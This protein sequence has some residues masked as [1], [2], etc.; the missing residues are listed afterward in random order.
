MK[1][2]FLLSAFAMFLAASTVMA[3]DK[4]ECAKACT[5]DHGNAACCKKG[6]AACCKKHAD[7]KAAAPT[8]D[9]K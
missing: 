3:G 2:V 8:N 5:K 6:N 1:K 9:K 7:E 4:K